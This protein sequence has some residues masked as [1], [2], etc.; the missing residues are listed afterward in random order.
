MLLFI[1]KTQPISHR[2]VL[3]ICLSTLVDVHDCPIVLTNPIRD[4]DAPS[5]NSRDAMLSFSA[6]NTRC[7]RRC[8]QLFF[9]N[10]NPMQT[11]MSMSSHA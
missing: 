1:I 10:P 5:R 4:F 7:R 11:T 9:T 2:I 8:V 6:M 3:F